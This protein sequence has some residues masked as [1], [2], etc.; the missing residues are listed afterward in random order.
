MSIMSSKNTIRAYVREGIPYLAL[1]DR[2]GVVLSSPGIVRIRTRQAVATL[3]LMERG[4]GRSFANTMLPKHLV[5]GRET[6]LQRRLSWLYQPIVVARLRWP[7]LVRHREN[8]RARG[9]LLSRGSQAAVNLISGRYSEHQLTG[10]VTPEI[11]ELSQIPSMPLLW[12]ETDVSCHK[13]VGPAP[14]RNL[15]RPPLEVL[16]LELMSGSKYSVYRGKKF[17]RLSQNIDLKRRMQTVAQTNI[18]PFAAVWAWT[19]D[20]QPPPMVRTCLYNGGSL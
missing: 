14:I 4:V 10:D 3:K 17:V 12:S 20:T 11:C 18:G 8:R 15:H 2:D 5:T 1:Y 9:P 7:G 6:L 13:Q 16:G 19:F